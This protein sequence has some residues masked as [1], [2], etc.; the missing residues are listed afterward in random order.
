MG[1]RLA[2]ATA[3][4]DLIADELARRRMG[5][6]ALASARRFDPALLARTYDE[7]FGELA[8]NRRSRAWERSQAV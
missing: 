8:A 5:E 1:D 3:L 6:A 7:L 4:L 2:L